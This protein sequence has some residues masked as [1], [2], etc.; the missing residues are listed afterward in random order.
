MWVGWV[1]FRW[2]TGTDDPL[3]QSAQQQPKQPGASMVFSNDGASIVAAPAATQ[4]HTLLCG[5][6]SLMAMESR[7]I[8]GGL[9]ADHYQLPGV[10]KAI[11][12]VLLNKTIH[13]HSIDPPEVP[14]VVT[15]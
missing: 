15:Q 12:E 9:S 1:A 13:N 14:E 4:V 10:P 8:A 7:A 6:R 5:T 2:M 11:K 3:V